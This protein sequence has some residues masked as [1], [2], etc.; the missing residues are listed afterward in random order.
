MVRVGAVTSR[1]MGGYTQRRAG[2][3]PHTHAQSRVPWISLAHP[4]ASTQ[5]PSQ[6]APSP[7][8]CLSSRRL[9]AHA[10]T[11][12]TDPRH[13]RL[14]LPLTPASRY[15]RKDRRPLDPPPVVQLT[16][17]YIVRPPSPSVADYAS[18]SAPFSPPHSLQFLTSF[19]SPAMRPTLASSVTSTSFRSRPNT[20]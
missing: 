18:E 6:A 1:G 12:P 20:M 17:S 19:Y 16:L 15:A 8:A 13:P 4:S 9:T 5:G 2:F 10:S 3:R 7:P 11:S 14:V